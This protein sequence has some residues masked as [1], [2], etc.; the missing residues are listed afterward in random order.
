MQNWSSPSSFSDHLNR[1]PAGH[2]DHC[3]ADVCR[4]IER[5]FARGHQQRE[6][7]CILLAPSTTQPDHMHLAG[8]YETG[9][10]FETANIASLAIRVRARRGIGLVHRQPLVRLL[11]AVI[12]KFVVH[13]PLPQGFD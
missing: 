3:R 1:N 6:Q 8:V 4:R 2:Q 12:V 5:L 11:D 10:R 9:C 7:S 13:L